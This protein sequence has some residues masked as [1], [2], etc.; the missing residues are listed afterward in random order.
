MTKEEMEQFVARLS[1][2]DLELL[3]FLVYVEQIE[4]IAYREADLASQG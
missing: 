3:A 2:P 1:D 4:R